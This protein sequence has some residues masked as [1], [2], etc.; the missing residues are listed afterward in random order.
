MFF[1]KIIDEIFKELKILFKRIRINEK[2]ISYL[3][4]E[5]VINLHNNFSYHN[6]RSDIIK[7]LKNN[8]KRH[9]IE[10]KI[11]MPNIIL[12]PKDVFFY[13]EKFSSPTYVGKKNV[14]GEIFHIN[15]LKNK[16][17]FDLDNKI[18]CIKHADPG[19]D[20]IFLKKIK[21]L[22]T[23]FGGPNSHMYI[24]AHE[25]DLPA[26][27]GIG[28]NKYLEIINS[29]KVSLNCNEKLISSI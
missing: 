9:S 12:K 17:D 7:E 22:I 15:D 11:N 14:I 20:F 5:T 4:L 6:I 29:K 19:Y 28:E 3:N 1:S 18:I 2:Y 25:F 24:R 23:E 21:G 8:I 26:A 16:K 13:E 10:S 27:I